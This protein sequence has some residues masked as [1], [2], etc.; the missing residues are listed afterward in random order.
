[1]ST[2]FSLALF[3]KIIVHDSDWFLP[4]STFSQRVIHRFL[5]LKK[6]S[7][8]KGNFQSCFLLLDLTYV[9]CALAVTSYSAIN[10]LS[11]HQ[12]AVSSTTNTCIDLTVLL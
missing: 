8:C 10:H 1:M 7:V 9:P 11:L 3:K 2:C 4:E 5:K 6:L 12:K